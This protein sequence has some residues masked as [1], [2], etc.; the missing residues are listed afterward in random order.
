MHWCGK[1]GVCGCATAP[2]YPDKRVGRFFFF[3]F[4]RLL[5]NFHRSGGSRTTRKRV[6]FFL[7]VCVCVCA[8]GLWK[9]RLIIMKR[10]NQIFEKK[11]RF[12]WNNDAPMFG[13]SCVHKK[14]RQTDTDDGSARIKESFFVCVCNFINPAWMC[15]RGHTIEVA[16]VCAWVESVWTG[17]GISGI[18]VS[19]KQLFF[20]W[21]E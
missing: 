8:G 17:G 6:S 9:S 15:A 13:I 18:C 19:L 2:R 5:Q 10:A 4:P 21:I 12:G 7:F 14:K 3:H 16:S 20:L 11:V 1:F